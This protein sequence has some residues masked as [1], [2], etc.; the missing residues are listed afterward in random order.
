[1]TFTLRTACVGYESRAAPTLTS[2]D[3]GPRI[4][5]FEAKHPSV[6]LP[7]VTAASADQ[8]AIQAKTAVGGAADNVTNDRNDAGISLFGAAPAKAARGADRWSSPFGR[9]G[10]R[11]S[12]PADLPRGLILDRPLGLSA[13]ICG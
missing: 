1:M 4:V 11:W 13:S 8:A 5:G 6:I 10:W 12:G 7:I 2:A 3:V 9:S